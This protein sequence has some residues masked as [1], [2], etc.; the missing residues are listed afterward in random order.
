MLFSNGNLDNF[1]LVENLLLQMSLNILKDNTFDFIISDWNN[2]E[3]VDSLGFFT[4]KNRINLQDKFNER[5]VLFTR[6]SFLSGDYEISS[7]ID[8]DILDSI[9][10][11]P[12]SLESGRDG[13]IVLNKNKNDGRK[14]KFLLIDEYDKNMVYESKSP[15]RKVIKTTLKHYN[16]FNNYKNGKIF[17]NSQTNPRFS[18]QGLMYDK[19]VESIET[20][21]P[22]LRL[23][24][25]MDENLESENNLYIPYNM[26]PNKIAYFDI[27]E[28][29]HRTDVLRIILKSNILNDYLYYYLNSNKGINDIAYLTLDFSDIWSIFYLW[30]PVPPIDEQKR[31][32]DAA[33]KMEGFF[34]A[35]D[36]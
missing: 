5:L 15:P 3:D 26:N 27:P 18:F 23:I 12:Y 11:L 6:F 20:D 10:R 21:V 35:M 16:N 4:H 33:R 34:N 14:N 7:F 32:V 9:I 2:Q 24:E 36:I 17:Q 22:M 8:E 29:H 25:L 19:T 1:S 28:N 30:V 13:V 31:I